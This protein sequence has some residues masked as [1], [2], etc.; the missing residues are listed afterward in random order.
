M[1]LVGPPFLV[2]VEEDVPSPAELMCHGGVVWGEGRFPHLRGEG[3]GEMGTGTM[4]GTGRK[5]VDIG[6]TVNNKKKS[7]YFHGV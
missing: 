3:E 7:V 4:E 2:S 1:P 6:C 5:G